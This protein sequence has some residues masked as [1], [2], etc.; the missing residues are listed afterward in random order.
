MSLKPLSLHPALP[1]L[2]RSSYVFAGA[3]LV[4]AEPGVKNSL[5]PARLDRLLGEAR[6]AGWSA[7]LLDP[8]P[9]KLILT[10]D[11]GRRID[12]AF[13]AVLDAHDATAIFFVCTAPRLACYPDDGEDKTQLIQAS[14]KALY[15][16][17]D[18]GRNQVILAPSNDNGRKAAIERKRK[19]TQKLGL[20]SDR[21]RPS[22]RYRA[23]APRRA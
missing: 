11:D 13:A 8:N 2:N 5:A 17:K 16:A 20:P 21:R 1:G 18:G 4:T 3:H 15:A 12:D 22:G 6:E 19:E 23:G 10:F 7:N 14:D 9:R